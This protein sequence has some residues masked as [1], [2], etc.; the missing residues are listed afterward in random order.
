[1]TTPIKRPYY[2]W[3]LWWES[4]IKLILDFSFATSTW[5]STTGT[6]I[7]WPMFSSTRHIL[8]L[9]CVTK[10]FRKYS[11]LLQP[12]LSYPHSTRTLRLGFSSFLCSAPVNICICIYPE[13]FLVRLHHLVLISFLCY[14]VGKKYLE[15]PE[16][17]EIWDFWPPVFPRIDPI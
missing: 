1:M 2:S 13:A 4:P 16:G 12:L 17:K 8:W 5:K 15:S 3:H 9:Q 7:I 14:L 11:W 10:G 6:N